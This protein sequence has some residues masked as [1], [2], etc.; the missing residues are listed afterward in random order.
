MHVGEAAKQKEGRLNLEEILGV[1]GG[2][3]GVGG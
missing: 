3:I 2:T 1:S